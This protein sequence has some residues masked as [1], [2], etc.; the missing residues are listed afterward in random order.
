ME[1]SVI[2]IPFLKPLN[3]EKMLQ[4]LENKKIVVTVEEHSCFGGLESVMAEIMAEN[5]V[6]APL[7]RLCLPGLIDCVGSQKELRKFYGIDAESIEKYVSD[8]LGSV[9]I[10]EF[11]Y[12]K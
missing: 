10:L 11:R 6:H 1:V 2:G 7:H 12:S 4:V 3:T 9:P 5:A 8:V